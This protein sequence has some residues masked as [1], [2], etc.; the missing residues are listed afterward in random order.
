MINSALAQD[1]LRDGS[2]RCEALILDPNGGLFCTARGL[3]VNTPV[4]F[5]GFD[6]SGGTILGVTDTPIPIDTE[7][8]NDAPAIFSLNVS[9]ELEIDADGVGEIEARVTVRTV[10]T[11]FFQLQ[12][13]IQEDTGSGFVTIASTVV[14]GGRGTLL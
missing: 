7:D 3:A 12:V 1:R 4:F 5:W 10:D 2:V 14:P 13:A 8:F 6:G 11:G 9:D